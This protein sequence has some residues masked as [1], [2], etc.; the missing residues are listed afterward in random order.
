MN[1]NGW[2]TVSIISWIVLAIILALGIFFNVSERRENAT[3]KAEVEKY[4]SL[5]L[6]DGG[7]DGKDG[8]R[9]DSKDSKDSKDK[10]SKDTSTNAK[11]NKNGGTNGGTSCG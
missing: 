7:T 9:S 2:K 3:L 8:S 11:D 5:A 6:V 1:N 4:K 10:D